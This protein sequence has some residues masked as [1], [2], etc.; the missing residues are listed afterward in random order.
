MTAVDVGFGIRNTIILTLERQTS[1]GAFSA[2]D[3]NNGAGTTEFTDDHGR[4]FR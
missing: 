3:S 4:V 1:S 2:D